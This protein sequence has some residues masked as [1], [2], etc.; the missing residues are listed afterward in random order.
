VQGITIHVDHIESVTITGHPAPSLRWHVGPIVPQRRAAMPLEVSL[1]TEEQV[2][3]SITPM[4]PAGAPAQV[5]GQAQWTVEGTC[6]VA[7]IDATS[8]WVLAGAIG[9][10]VV[11]VAC[12]ADLGAGVVPLGDTCLVHVANPMAASLGLSAEAPIL[13]TDAPPA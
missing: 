5:D 8:A 12:D 3:L 9:D 6:T 11:T 1:S 13:K 4:T 7:P 2:R 10:S